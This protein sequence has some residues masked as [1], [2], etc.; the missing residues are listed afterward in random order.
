LSPD[1]VKYREEII[2]AEK[3]AREN[4]TGCKWGKSEKKE[5]EKKFKW[6]RLTAE[7]LGLEVVGA[8]EAKK[9]IGERIII[10]GKV[11]DAYHH[12]KSNTVFLN[13][14]YRLLLRF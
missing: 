2:L 10:Q 13:L 3:E 1:D 8:C 9:Y 14:C 12:L 11:V 5:G 6:R 4:K 7:K